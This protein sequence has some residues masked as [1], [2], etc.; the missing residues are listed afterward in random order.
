MAASQRPSDRA[1]GFDGG[2]LRLRQASA[3]D[4]EFIYRLVEKTMRG[5]VEKTWGTFSEEYNRKHIADTIAAGNYSIIRHGADDAGALSVDRHSGFLYLAQLF[6]LPAH[7]S[8]GIG[9]RIVR[10]LV[11]EAA[12]SRK[13]L[14]LRVLAVN[15]AKAFYER[16]GFHVCATTSERIYMQWTPEGLETPDGECPAAVRSLLDACHI[17][18]DM[19]AARFLSFQPEAQELVTAEV[20]DRG[21]EHRLTPAAAGAWREMRTAAHGEGVAIMIVS[22]FR[23]IERQAEIIRAKLARGLLIEDIL[24][25]SAPPGYSEHHSGRALDVTTEGVQALELEFEETTAFKWLGENAA[26][27]GFRLSFPRDNSSGYAYEPWHWC[28]RT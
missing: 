10:A 11:K 25:V 16:E 7:Q 5:Y 8:K 2:D 12:Y 9:T 18:A 4:A 24:K 21:R 27:F 19:I 6:V 3:A 22:A 28:F 23:G 1:G 20:D 17:S 26:R 14:R 13:P 15:P